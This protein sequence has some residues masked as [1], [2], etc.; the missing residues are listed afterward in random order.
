MSK[1]TVYIGL[2]SNVQYR[3]NIVNYFMSLNRF[4]V[5]RKGSYI[6][7]YYRTITDNSKSNR[8]LFQNLLNKQSVEGTSLKQP[9][10]VHTISS[11]LSSCRIRWW[12]LLGIFVG[13]CLGW[14]SSCDTVPDIITKH[15][16][17]FPWSHFIVLL[18]WPWVN[19]AIIPRLCI[20]CF[21]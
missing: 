9:N 14:Y 1:I 5:K 15:R 4:E 10:Q 8:K 17:I 11:F 2:H 19:P 20:T 21:G 3:S 6:M 13:K 16:N 18:W 12:Y 7:K